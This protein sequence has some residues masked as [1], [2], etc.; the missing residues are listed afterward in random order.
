[1]T[2]PHII[3]A[4]LFIFAVI[5]VFFHYKYKAVENR[6]VIE[7]AA[8]ATGLVAFVLSVIIFA[9][10]ELIPPPTPDPVVTNVTE[11]IEEEKFITVT[12]TAFASQVKGVSDAQNGW[13]TQEAA[14]MN[15]RQEL[16]ATLKIHIKSET[17]QVGGAIVSK[18]VES[19]VDHA[20]QL[21]E[22][23]GGKYLLDG[24]YE[25]VMKAPR[26]VT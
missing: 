21:S 1:M 25:L 23:V 10:P 24:S 2:I 14:K 11:V 9:F 16:A 19:K 20:L 15:C 7:V 3:S 4:V 22:I 17:K 13:L 6:K 5:I 18:E 12:C 26:P 8:H